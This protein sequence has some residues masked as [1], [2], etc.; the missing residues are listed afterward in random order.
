[1]YD[2]VLIH[3]VVTQQAAAHASHLLQTTRQIE[4]AA[5]VDTAE[6]LTQR[7]ECQVDRQR[8]RAAL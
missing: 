3:D 6:E 8:L 2:C 5:G 1:M 4:E 7:L